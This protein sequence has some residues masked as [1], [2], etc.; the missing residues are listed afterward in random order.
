P[1]IL[2]HALADL[3]AIGARSPHG[4]LFAAGTA[5]IFVVYG[6]T[7]LRG[8]TTEQCPPLHPSGTHHHRS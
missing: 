4:D 1:L 2:L 8:R 3:T 5:V 7:V 6:V